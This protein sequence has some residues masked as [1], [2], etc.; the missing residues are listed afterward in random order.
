VPVNRLGTR[1]EAHYVAANYLIGEGLDFLGLGGD[2][3][4]YGARAVHPVITKKNMRF[5]LA[6]GIQH[7]HVESLITGEKRIDRT[8]TVHAG[9][10]FDNLDRFLGKNIVFFDYR[11]GHLE[12]QTEHQ[13]SNTDA[14]PSYQIVKLDLA[15]IQKIYGYTSLLARGSGQYSTERLVSSEQIVLGGYGSVRGWEPATTIGDAGYTLSAELM[16][17]PPFVEDKKLFG[18]RA[19]QMFQLAAFYD[20]GQIYANDPPAGTLDTETLAGAGFGVRLFYKDR[21]TFK[22]DAGFPVNKLHG[23]PSVIHYFLGSINFF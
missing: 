16:M 22:Y 15:R 21:F 1:L 9:F 4:I 10:N 2:T 5:E 19:T 11:H 12:P 23:E 20:F 14:A 3:E 6:A 7:K 13:W 18:L 8:N 17:A